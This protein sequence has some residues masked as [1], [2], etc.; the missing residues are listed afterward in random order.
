[1]GKRGFV[2]FTL[3]VVIVT[4][5]A[6]YGVVRM[7]VDETGLGLPKVEHQAPSDTSKGGTR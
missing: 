1:M 3:L 7:V 6:V 4:A 2:V 5:A